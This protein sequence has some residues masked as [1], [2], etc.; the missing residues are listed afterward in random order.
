MSEPKLIS[1][2]LDNYL[3]GEPISEHHGIRCCP[4]VPKKSDKRY[5]VKIISIPA[6]QVQLDALLLAG[7][8]S[9]YASAFSYFKELADS[10]ASE[11]EVLN[12][13]SKLE[14][15]LPYEA[16]QLVPMEGK[17]GYDVYLMSQYK[18]TLER[19]W[20]KKPMTHLAAVNL[21]L[22]LCAAMAVCRRSGYLYVDLKPSNIYI[23][24][25][26]EYRVGDLGFVR[27][28]SLLY[29]SLPDKYRSV[30]T[31]PEIADA[32]SSLNETIDTYAIGMILYQV[33]N[34]G[35]LPTK[36]Q[37]TGGNLPA[38][39]Y[40]DSDMAAIIMKAISADPGERWPDPIQMGQALVSYM[41]RNSINDT[42]IIPLPD[43]TIAEEAPPSSEQNAPESEEN[44][45]SESDTG[46]A[47]G[48]D[49][50]DLTEQ[51]DAQAAEAVV[52]D[53]ISDD[54]T[55]N[56][57]YHELSD[58]TSDML[59]QADELLALEMPEPVVAPEPIDV[60]M[61]APISIEDIPD[62]DE[63]P[64]AVIPEDDASAEQSAEEDEEEAVDSEEAESE[65]A[66]EEEVLSD[67][68]PESAD[69][70]EYYEEEAYDAQP[71]KR[72]WG[73]L[74]AI[75]AVLALLAALIGGG[76][77]YYTTYYL[78]TIDHMELEGA[79]DY[80]RISLV[81]DADEDLL[82]VICT[83][84]YGNSRLAYV[85]DGIATFN[86]LTPGTLYQIR[87]EIDGFHELSG[88]IS[89]TYTTP[90]QTNILRFDAIT[91]SNDGSVILSFSV[92]GQD[93]EN[94][95]VTY[96]AEDENEQTVSF[97]GH[98]VTI[99]GLTVGKTYTFTLSSPDDLYIVGNNTVSFTSAQLI[100][101]AD[102][103]ITGCDES[104]LRVV[105]SAAENYTVENWTVHCYN[106]TYDQT[107][108]T[109]DLSATFTGID[110][111]QAYTVE[112]IAQG[113]TVGIRDYVTA[114]S[115]T[116]T[117]F[118][119]DTTVPFSLSLSWTY[120]GV[121]PEEGWIVI[122]NRIA[123]DDQQVV[124]IT[125]DT[126]TISPVLPGE[127]YSFT[128]QASDGTTVFDG[129]FSC[130]VPAAESFEGYLITAG[131]ITYRTCSYPGY[132]GWNH[133]Q[134]NSSHYTSTFAPSARICLVAQLH[135]DYDT[136]DDPITIQ[137]VIR[138]S[139]GDLAGMC[140]ST[141]AW[142]AIWDNY[143]GALEI[144]QSGIP[145]SPGTYTLD[146]YF[147]NM[148]TGSLEFTIV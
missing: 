113:M 21:G 84:T 83:D 124:Q 108:V 66:D 40:A 125:E 56:I 115:A 71:K 107:I 12:K 58:E 6:S 69:D 85:T 120:T 37:I 53:I 54:I 147:N 123:S 98:L 129:T 127:S 17:V 28:D 131:D 137:Y 46:D 43:S 20:K 11:V 51:E 130:D 52:P 3:M 134:L 60:P 96:T 146:I 116:I 18:R 26:Q 36:E 7:A 13:L 122:Y 24:D 57:A 121:A 95:V 64:I 138:S 139:D 117:G 148:I 86:D 145:A 87:V 82:R 110:P 105:W 31:P 72:R 23:S 109:S 94:W 119:A 38:P 63:I 68:E 39:A 35:Q 73:S 92:D 61:P 79:N 48:S 143:Y 15:F 67:E 9:N 22:D 25:Q 5:I 70:E 99:N 81:T 4:A 126:I 30:Y 97:T 101:A 88:D 62:E 114:N 47:P 44:P 14:G 135:A 142:S 75:I 111:T 141:Q 144:P 77:Y 49:R 93:A 8:Y 41:Q 65:E 90:A 100:Y 106:D 91:G 89:G 80:L 32:M 33:Y 42:P 45:V 10:I 128:I 2:M 136:S 132:D 133:L 112:V 29:A 74:I 19:H 34:D 78:Q 118:Q 16:I 55:G 104:G 103:T 76:Y 59:A 1:P 50:N 140:S 27:M 102:V